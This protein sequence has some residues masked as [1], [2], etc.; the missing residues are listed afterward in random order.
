MATGIF[1]IGTSALAAAQTGLLTTG[2]NISNASTVGFHRQE[3]VQRAALPQMTGAGF[4]GNGVEVS[5]VRRMYDQFLNGQVVQ[6]QGESSRLDAYYTQIK[7]LDD[8]LADANAG[9]APA[10]QQFFTATHDVAANPSSVP[11]R[12]A[13]LSASSSLVSRFH[14]L[15]QR[16]E[17]IRAGVN[18]QITAS[19]SDINSYAQQIA[20]LNRQ[21]VTAQSAG[22]GQPA[23]DLLDQRD[24]L[25]RELNKEVGATVVRQSDGNYNVFIGNGQ[26]L[27]VGGEALTLTAG[28]VPDDP[29]RVGVAYQAGGTTVRIPEGSLQGGALTGYLDF[30]SEAL[31]SAQNALGR[32]AAGL[33]QTFNDQHALGQDLEGNLGGA[34]FK[35]PVPTVLGNSANATGSRVDASIVDVGALTTSD[36]RLTYDGATYT[37]TRLSDG[38]KATRTNPAVT[39]LVLDG[40]QVTNPSMSAGDSFLMQPTR[41]AAQQ[42]DVLIRDTAKIAA[43][44][45]IRTAAGS[46]NSG[47]ASISAGSV[48]PATTVNANLRKPVTITFTGPN[49]YDVTG[50]G[51]GSPTGVAYPGVPAGVISYNGWTAQIT[52]TPAAGDT[53]TISANTGGTADN[54]NA[55]LL[56]SLAD[57]KTLINGTATY[58]STYGQLVSEVGNKTR[59]LEVT[60]TAQ[61]NLLDQTTRAQDALSGVNLD[62]EAANLLRYQQ[63]YQASGKVLQIASRLFDT[64]LAIGS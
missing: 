15:Q 5:T 12:Q 11:S 55:L 10:L 23:N 25:V 53:F 40:V 38:T 1:G 49:T 45:P 48:V 61:T 35:T 18:M 50:M 39:P 58:Q 56:A 43:A 64:V 7:Q 2:H 44:A 9:L 34:Y 22:Q 62:E 14:A 32:I 17:E 59:E 42:I 20:A 28:P 29:G 37:L 52:G 51:T 6:A 16:Y 3:V 27:V 13:M 26:A 46:A 21:I 60:S 8:M 54:R 24:E 36:Y 47:S 41:D 31:D 30:R 57:A 4:I 63:A 19:V 33:A